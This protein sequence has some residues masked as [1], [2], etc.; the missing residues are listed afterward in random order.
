MNS[1]SQPISNA[2]V[3][4]SV[5]N[6]KFESM[7]AICN[8]CLFDATHDM[9]LI[10][11]VNDVNVRSKSKSKRNKKRKVW[12]PTGK[13]FTEIRY[14]WKPTG[15]NFTIIGNR[16]PLT[17]ITSNKIVPHKETPI[18][19]VVTPTSG[20]LVYNMRPKAT[21]S[22]GSSNKVK[23]VESK[24]SNSKEPK[25]YWGSTVSDVP[26]SSLNDCKLSK[27]FG[28]DHIA[29]I[30]GYGDYQMGNVTICRAYYVEGFGHNLFSV[31][32]FCDS[33][34][35]VAFR[36]HTYFIR[37]LDG[38]DLLKGSRG[39][40]LYTLSMDNLLLSSLIC[41]LSKAS[42]TNKKHSH[43]PKAEDSI[44][45]KLYLLHMDLCGP[46]RIQSINGR[47]YILVIVDDY[48][49]FTWVKF[50]QS[51]DEVSEFVIKFLKMI[52]VLLNAI[53]RNIRTDN[54]TEFINQ[55]LKAYYEEVGI[56]HQTSMAR[57][58]QQNGVV[59]I[60]NRTLVEAARTMLIFL[61]ALLFLWA[62][63]VATACYT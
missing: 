2:L 8:K 3:K 52:Q 13:V 55:T 16:C 19:L 27:L 30:M 39:S 61:K 21:R 56:S 26:S 32:Q 37:D 46:M 5:R 53:V 6:A 44:Q 18:A 22:V 11:H 1:V 33:D 38:V 63:A 58:L 54:G 43:K 20:I 51:K 34:L 47:K 59:K 62:Y 12:N 28:N 40:N 41:L 45:E 17:R 4:H 9:F 24:T 36:R 48:S 35:K 31:G 10:D 14:S 23:I 15:R 50:L 42:K 25:Q 60:Q 57:T 29:K 49:R 7:C